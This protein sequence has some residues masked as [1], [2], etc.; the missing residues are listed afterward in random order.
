MR[1][2]CNRYLIIAYCYYF[3]ESID[4]EIII[5][6]LQENICWVYQNA[7]KKEEIFAHRA[8]LLYII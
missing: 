1:R 2:Q 6:T 8:S 5:K 7:E 3:I 4:F